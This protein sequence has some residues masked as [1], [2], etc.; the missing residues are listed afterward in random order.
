MIFRFQ[1]RKFRQT[2]LTETELRLAYAR[3][4]LPAFKLTEFHFGLHRPISSQQVLLNLVPAFP[5]GSRTRATGRFRDA[6]LSRMEPSL[7]KQ[8]DVEDLDLRTHSGIKSSEAN[9][10][11]SVQ[12]SHGSR[13]GVH[14]FTSFRGI[15]FLFQEGMAQDCGYS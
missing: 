4:D 3:K 11:G 6:C 9:S 13:V 1:Q 15:L 10:E 2:H 14:K 12:V 5:S 8:S 7:R